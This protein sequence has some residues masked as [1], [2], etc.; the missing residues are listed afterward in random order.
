M[1]APWVDVG[2]RPRADLA[3]NFVGALLTLDPNW[4]FHPPPASNDRA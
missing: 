2:V 1:Q 3:E 4:G